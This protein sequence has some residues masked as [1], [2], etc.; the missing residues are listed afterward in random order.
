MKPLDLFLQALGAQLGDLPTARR[1]EI[2]DETRGHLEAMIAA[3]RADGMDEIAAWHSARNAFGD[4]E[5]VGR[6]LAREWHRDPRIETV[7]TPLS[8]AAKRR[9]IA[10]F[11]PVLLIF[12]LAY[13]LVTWLDNRH[14]A[15]AFFLMFA[16][17]MLGYSIWRQR[18]QGLPFTLSA[19]AGMLISFV[20]LL[21]LALQIQFDAQLRDTPLQAALDAYFAPII[22]VVGLITMFFQREQNKKVYPWRAGRLYA[23]NPVAAE[24]NY[25]LSLR[26]CF[27]GFT[28][29]QCFSV[30]WMW[31]FFGIWTLLG[32]LGVVT[33]NLLVWRWIR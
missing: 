21:G 10:G 27:I 30:L 5:I 4:A 32:C 33:F 20:F 18:R 9:K 2:L 15:G 22:A 7:G 1:A 14:L 12:P 29:I 26:L 6:E 31:P 23:T 16:P 17:L 28:A 13:P 19:I 25:R 3:R 8:E 24:D 11:F